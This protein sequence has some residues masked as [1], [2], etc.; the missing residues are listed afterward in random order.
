M[1]T[2]SSKKKNSFDRY[3]TISHTTTKTSCQIC[4]KSFSSIKGYNVHISN[5]KICMLNTFSYDPLKVYSSDEFTHF[6]QVHESTPSIFKQ[7]MS[8][9]NQYKLDGN[10]DIHN[11]RNVG[12]LSIA[13]NGISASD[14]IAHDDTTLFIHNSYSNSESDGCESLC[15]KEP[16]SYSILDQWKYQE[17]I[18]DTVVSAD[19]INS[20]KLANILHIANSPLYHFDSIMKWASESTRNNYKFPHIPQS[21]KMFFQNLYTNYDLH[22]I[23]PVLKRLIL[24]ISGSVVEVISFNMEQLLLSILNNKEL[25]CEDNLLFEDGD[26]F[27]FPRRRINTVGDVN[28]GSWYIHAYNHLCHGQ[29][30]VLVPIIFL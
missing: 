9:V 14:D 6:S 29:N 5:N 1:T 26:P 17:N 8:Y 16:C 15:Q 20:T 13:H 27:S 4:A 22:G 23:A 3:N 11:D 10:P 2:N 25:M 19:D 7:H 28:S 24:P 18:P 30:D 21:R 12:K